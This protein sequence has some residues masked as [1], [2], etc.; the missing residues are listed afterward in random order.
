VRLGGDSL[1]LCEDSNEALALDESDR[2]V[3]PGA[4]KGVLAGDLD[5]AQELPFPPIP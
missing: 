1:L 4:R 2:R 3:L 5:A